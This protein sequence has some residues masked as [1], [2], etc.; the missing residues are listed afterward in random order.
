[1]NDMRRKI[2]KK[3]DKSRIRLDLEFA[4]YCH[5]WLRSACSYY[6]RNVGCVYDPGYAPGYGAY[7][8]F[9]ILPACMI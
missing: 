5:W 1:M 3:S 4:P 6:S 9:D 8:H 2:F 7:N